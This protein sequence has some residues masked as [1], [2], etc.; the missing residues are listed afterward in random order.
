MVQTPVLLQDL[1]WASAGRNA[2][3]LAV[4]HHGVGT[5]L[6]QQGSLGP[7]CSYGQLARQVEQWAA[8][9]MGLGLQR[10]ERVLNRRE[11]RD[12]GRDRAVHINI[13]TPDIENFRRAR[14][15][16]AADIARAV[17]FGRRGL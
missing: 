3:A 13:A 4:T 11:A 8:G 2:Q 5:A 14:T 6:A 7:H 10:G 1:L 17:S 16:V 12:Y 15:Q 9:L